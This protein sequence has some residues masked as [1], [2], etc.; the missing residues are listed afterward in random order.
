[1]DHYF[2]KVLIHYCHLWEKYN[3]LPYPFF[4]RDAKPI[5]FKLIEHCLKPTNVIYL[6]LIRDKHCAELKLI[7][8]TSAILNEIT[9]RLCDMER[10]EITLH[11]TRGVY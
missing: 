5:K 4:T 1:M 2:F 10:N 3:N 11:F 9:L 7:E 8:R 6:I